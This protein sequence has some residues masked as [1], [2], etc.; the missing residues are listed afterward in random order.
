MSTIEHCTKRE[1]ITRLKVKCY[2]PRRCQFSNIVIFPLYAWMCVSGMNMKP[3][4]CEMCMDGILGA[5]EVNITM[6][7][8]SGL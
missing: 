1:L 8:L 6:Q 3:S 5:E 4:P 7:L 2:F